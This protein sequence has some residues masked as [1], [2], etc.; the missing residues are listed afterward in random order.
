[1]QAFRS[2]FDLILKLFWSCSQFPSLFSRKG[3]DSSIST[4]N[5]IHNHEFDEW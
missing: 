4:I 3:I 5:H 1:M 2:K